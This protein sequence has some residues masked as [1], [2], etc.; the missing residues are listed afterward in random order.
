[1]IRMNWRRPKLN[2][3]VLKD[4][5]RLEDD[6]HKIVLLFTHIIWSLINSDSS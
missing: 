2:G 4:Y 3:V 1:M 6:L 5:I